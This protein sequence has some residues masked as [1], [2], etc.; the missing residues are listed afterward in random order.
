ML[1][2]LISSLAAA[3]TFPGQPWQQ[4][5]IPALCSSRLNIYP[6]YHEG[7]IINSRAEDPTEPPQKLEETL[8]SLRDKSFRDSVCPEGQVFRQISISEYRDRDFKGPTWECVESEPEKVPDPVPVPQP[9]PQ[10]DP[11]PVTPAPTVVIKPSVA[12]DPVLA[13]RSAS[14]YAICAALGL[15]LLGAGVWIGRQTR[16]D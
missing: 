4:P 5:M 1:T 8:D 13:T 12:P 14:F 6:C 15:G 11:R 10:P 7:Q 16:R 2:L 3:Q 9:V